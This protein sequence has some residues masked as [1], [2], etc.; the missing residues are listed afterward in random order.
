VAASIAAVFGVANAATS[1]YWAVGGRGLLDTI[2]GEIERWGRSRSTEVVIV[3]WVVAVVKLAAAAVP[4][5]WASRRSDRLPS[6]ARS[7]ALAALGWVVSIGLTGYGGVLTGV[8]LLIQLDLVEAADGADSYALAWHTYFWDPW[9]LLWG[10]A[11][12]VAMW[13]SRTQPD[14]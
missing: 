12:T 5:V 14:T 11:S 13:Q 10:I 4:L 1:V 3:L 8:G 9:F 6:W 2:G 7:R